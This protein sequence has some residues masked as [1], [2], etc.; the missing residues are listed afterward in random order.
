MST[1]SADE[2]KARYEAKGAKRIYEG[3]SG[4]AVMG[5]HPAG[6]CASFA[7]DWLKKKAALKPVNESTYTVD[8][9]TWR[10]TSR[11]DKIVKRQRKYEATGGNLISA[12]ESYG[13]TYAWQR[14][15]VEDPYP[16]TLAEQF[17]T[18]NTH[19]PVGLYY[20]SF[21]ME[22]GQGH[23]IGYDRGA[24]EFCD[25]NSGIFDLQEMGA[26]VLVATVRDFLQDE[27]KAQCKHVQIGRVRLR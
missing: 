21:R 25:A 3:L 16:D 19:A 1:E 5:K 4:S 27:L 7:L 8:N 9:G 23:A 14:N 6:V 2:I 20:L 18:W 10:H 15:C 12:A 11:L 22:N 17:I 26:N 24:N 13:L